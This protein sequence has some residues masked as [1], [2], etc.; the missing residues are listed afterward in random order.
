VVAPR[1]RQAAEREHDPGEIGIR[2]QPDRRLRDGGDEERADH[3]RPRPEPAADP[4]RGEAA[5]DAADRPRGDERAE[6]DTVD[7]E[8]LEREQHEDREPGGVDER[9]DR[10]HG[11]E[12]SQQPVSPEPAE[13]LADG[14][15]ETGGRPALRPERASQ[16]EQNER[17][18]REGA[19]IREERRSRREPEQQTAERRA[20]E[21]VGTRPGHGQP[22]VRFLEQPGRHEGGNHRRRSRIDQRLGGPD[23]ER[24]RVQEH[25]R[26]PVEQHGAA[27]HE[28]CLP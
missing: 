3:R 9:E 6:G 11:G 20:G 18:D 19:G 26:R 28:R 22:P 27:E 23:D 21:L 16:A 8:D 24:Y 13:A 5:R 1:P 14:A 10:D 4:G 12:R 15:E 25:E 2:G 17:G 7:V